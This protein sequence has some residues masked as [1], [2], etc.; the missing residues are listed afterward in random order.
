MASDLGSE[1]E[2][3]WDVKQTAELICAK[4]Y[5]RV[6]LQVPDELLPQAASLSAALL[7]QCRQCGASEALQVLVCV[8][9]GPCLSPGVHRPAAVQ[10]FVLA[11]TSY[12]HE[13]VDQV[14]AEHARSQLTVSVFLTSLCCSA[15][16]DTYSLACSAGALRLCLPRTSLGTASV[17]RLWEEPSGRAAVCT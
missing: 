14:A 16:T 8:Q 4:A 5:I 11:D 7:A 10:V 2:I 1:L 15:C 12:N 3:T 17:L 9:Q 13:S 6:T